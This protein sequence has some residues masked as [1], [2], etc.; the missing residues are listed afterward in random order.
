MTEQEK[1]AVFVELMNWRRRRPGFDC[2]RD[3]PY[4]T[5]N[6][7]PIGNKVCPYA[8]DDEGLLQFAVILLQFPEVITKFVVPEVDGSGN[9][10]GCKLSDDQAFNQ[11]NV[12]DEILRMNEREM[13]ND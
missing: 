13:G 6:G 9:V 8:D 5:S 12:L 3:P 11:K 1:N 10:V 7:I 4:I 2:Y